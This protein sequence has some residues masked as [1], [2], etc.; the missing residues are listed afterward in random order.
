[1]S[2]AVAMHRAWVQDGP[3]AECRRRRRAWHG[4]PVFTEE[5]VRA[6][7]AVSGRAALRRIVNKLPGSDDEVVRCPGGG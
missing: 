1:M 4:I 2:P 5:D 7:R 6:G 3:S